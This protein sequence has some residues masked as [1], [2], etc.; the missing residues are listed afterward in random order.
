MLPH[1]QLPVRW[2]SDPWSGKANMEKE[3]VRGS[4]VQ[5]PDSAPTL[6]GITHVVGRSQDL[7]HSKLIGSLTRITRSTQSAVPSLVFLRI[8]ARS[9]RKTPVKGMHDLARLVRLAPDLL[10]CF[11]ATAQD[12]VPWSREGLLDHIMAFIVISD[13]VDCAARLALLGRLI[14]LGCFISHSISSTGP[15]FAPFS[16]S[17]GQVQKKR[18][19]RIAQRLP[20]R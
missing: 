10:G 9:R 6:G 1:P 19:F 7:A 16:N 4:Q 8:P 2:V 3:S 17:I 15:A 11:S 13:Q 12:I 14:Q 20:K 5:R 18:I